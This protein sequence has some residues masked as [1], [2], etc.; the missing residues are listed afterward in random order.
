MR[1]LWLVFRYPNP[2]A[3]A[4]NAGGCAVFP[5]LRTLEGRGLVTRNQNNYRLTRRGRDELAMTCA[6][7]QLVSRTGAQRVS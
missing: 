6:I 7:A 3:L 1:L 5:R 2:T 4:R